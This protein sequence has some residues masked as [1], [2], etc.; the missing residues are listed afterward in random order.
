M[1]FRQAILVAAILSGFVCAARAD[2][3]PFADSGAQASSREQAPQHSQN[4]DPS[5][6]G[7]SDGGQ[8][9]ASI[10]R[11]QIVLAVYCVLIVGA[12]LF[13]GWL[14]RRLQ[15]SHTR[16]Q[17]IISAI[18]GLMLSIGVFHML[19]HAIEELGEDGADHAA[20]GLMGGLVVMFLLLRIFSFHQ[21]S[22]S[23]HSIPSDALGHGQP[24]SD[25]QPRLR[26]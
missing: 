15:I 5:P 6:S 13:G 14:P 18:A 9:D 8:A 21:H 12:S 10:V 7:N 17:V 19:P 11:S 22:H 3:S 24:H 23:G 20:Y 2:Q 16:M 1:R 25:P 4:R 26:S